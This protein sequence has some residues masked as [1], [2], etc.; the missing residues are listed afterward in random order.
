[1][2]TAGI[3]LL[4]LA[5]LGSAC[6]TADTV[7]TDA[8]TE[9]TPVSTAA[10]VTTS[11]PTTTLPATTTTTLPLAE[12]SFVGGVPAGLSESVSTFLGARSTGDTPN[13][14]AEFTAHVTASIAPSDTPVAFT[15]NTGVV[16][17]E[18]V[19]VIHSAEGD[20][21]LAVSPNGVDWKIVGGDLPS[22]GVEPWFGDHLRQFYVI[23]SDARPGENPLRFRADSHHIVT[24]LP[25][26]SG[27]SIVGIP[28]DTYVE[29][30]EGTSG[31][32]TNV[33]ASNGPERVVA[34][35]TILTG[36]EFEGFAVTGFKGFVGMVDEI[37]GFEFDAPI[38]MADKNADAYFSSGLQHMTGAEALAYSRTRK[39]IAGGDFT[40]SF[41]HGLLMQWALKAVQLQGISSLPQKMETFVKWGWTDLSAEDFLTLSALAYTVDPF[42]LNN[43][44]VAGTPG[45]AGGASVVFLDDGYE[46]LFADLA[47]APWQPTGE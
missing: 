41:H 18:Q 11:A 17:D 14:T 12:A 29:T 9:P 2:R 6:A 23:G 5:V 19:A 3:T 34:T 45:S 37:G 47:I 38:G 21:L 24:L 20:L 25:D 15:I 36:I 1:M 13:A 32:F 10:P 8:P 16:Q 4:S 28:R 7:P 42:S 30:P 31:K 27:G 33:M 39:T 22:Y 35:A 46:E 26:A 44:V 43:H 40:R